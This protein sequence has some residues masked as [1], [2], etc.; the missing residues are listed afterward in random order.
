MP[1]VTIR[2]PFDKLDL[3]NQLRFEPHTVFHLFL[4]QGSL[5]AF[6]LR[7]V[8]KRASV[9][10]QSFEPIRNL[11]ANKWHKPI[12]H[13]GGIEELLALVIADY[14]CIKRISRRVAAY[15]KTPDRL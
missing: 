9:D 11:T 1:Q 8:C 3:G 13:L 12:S 5:R 10:L 14:Q 6:F 4:G 15:Y 7:Q 2:R